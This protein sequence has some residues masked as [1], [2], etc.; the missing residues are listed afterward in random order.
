MKRWASRKSITE[1]VL[2]PERTNE[3]KVADA[4]EGEEFQPGDRRYFYFK[5]DGSLSLLENFDGD[6]DKYK[7][8][9]K[10][11]KTMQ[12]FSTVLDVS[13]LPKYH[14]KTKRK[15]LDENEFFRVG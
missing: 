11:W 7:L 15:L 2:N 12:I 5:S 14:L 9:E 6:Y 10:I 8:I 3:Q 1:A 13:I 4:L